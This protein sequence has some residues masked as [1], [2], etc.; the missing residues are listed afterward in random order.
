MI[1]IAALWSS[2]LRFDEI[3]QH[4]HGDGAVATIK[5]RFGKTEEKLG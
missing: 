4:P 3:M 1:A 5:M 2:L